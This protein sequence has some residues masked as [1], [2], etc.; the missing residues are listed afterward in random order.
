MKP[1]IAALAVSAL[2][3]VLVLLFGGGSEATLLSAT[4]DEFAASLGLAEP[5]ASEEVGYGDEPP[6]FGNDAPPPLESL[7]NNQRAQAQLDAQAKPGDFV[8]PPSVSVPH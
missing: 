2:L 5:Q 7:R 1:A 6:L 4:P 8:T 3:A